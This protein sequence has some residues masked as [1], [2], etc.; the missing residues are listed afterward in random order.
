V[1]YVAGENFSPTGAVVIANYTNGATK[2]VTSSCTWSPIALNFGDN[3]VICTYTENNRTMTLE[4]LITVNRSTIST[5]P[6]Q[7]NTL[8]YT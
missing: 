5:V 4:V 6:S 3:K 2:N 7:A 1:S 8:T